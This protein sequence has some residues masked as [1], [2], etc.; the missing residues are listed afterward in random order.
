MFSAC[1]LTA[2]VCGL[3]DIGDFEFIARICIWSLGLLAIFA[4]LPPP[5]I[6]FYFIAYFSHVVLLEFLYFSMGC[7]KLFVGDGRILAC[8]P[9]T[10]MVLA[11]IAWGGS[12]AE[13]HCGPHKWSPMIPQRASLYAP[14]GIKPNDVRPIV[15]VVC[16][17]PWKPRSLLPT[18]DEDIPARYLTENTTIRRQ[19]LSHACCPCSAAKSTFSRTTWPERCVSLSLIVL[20]GDLR[21]AGMVLG[22]L[23]LVSTFIP[24]SLLCADPTARS[25]LPTAHWPIAEAAPP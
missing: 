25:C 2:C 20:Q 18:M 8:L 24:L 11:C 13:L 6:F 1:S 9:L 14:N 4:F 16:F 10:Q 12:S 22:Y 19:C 15:R 3:S 17:L 23:S 5:L 21:A 7:I